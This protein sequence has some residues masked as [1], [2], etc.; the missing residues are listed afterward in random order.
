MRPLHQQRPWV[1]H[2]GR[3]YSSGRLLRQPT[4][5]SHDLLRLLLRDEMPAVGK[6]VAFDRV[7]DHRHHLLNFFPKRLFATEG[8]HRD[9]HLMYGQGSSL[10]HRCEGGAV[11]AICPQNTFN[12]R[13]TAQIFINCGGLDRSRISRSAFVEPSQK[14]PLVSD[15]QPFE[16]IRCERENPPPHRAL[17]HRLWRVTND[18]CEHLRQHD[19][20]FHVKEPG[21][22]LGIVGRPKK[23][24]RCAHIMS[25]QQKRL[26]RAELGLP[27]EGP[28]FLSESA[29][30][31]SLITGWLVGVPV[32]AHA[33]RCPR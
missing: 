15:D 22:L 6:R 21:N 18:L 11:Y 27:N 13:E 16:Y 17:F 31:V 29:G 3:D 32:S 1:L 2:G 7:G 8:D 10:I 4:D 14:F 20:H 5:V 30:I 25:S 28:E 19:R 9:P 33:P 24:W 26:T 23:S 12:T